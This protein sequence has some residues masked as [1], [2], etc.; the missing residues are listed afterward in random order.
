M[1]TYK[2]KLILC[3]ILFVGWAMNVSAQSTTIKTLEHPR[4][5]MTKSDEAL[6][7][8][9]VKTNKQW[10]MVDSLLMQGA[11]DILIIPVSERIVI[12]RRLLDVSRETLRRILILGYA[13]RISGDTKYSDRAEIEL[14]AVSEFSDW[15][16]SHFLDVAEMTTAVAI[17]Y[18]W[19]YD[20]LTD[21]AKTKI[22]LAILQKGIDPSLDE[23]YNNWLDRVNNWNQVCNTGM[24]YGVIAIYEDIPAIADM[25][26]KRSVESV[27]KPMKSYAPDGAYPEG[28]SY[29]GYGT[30][31][32]V[33]LIDAL[34]KSFGTDFGLSQQQGFLQTAEYML[35]MIAPDR[36]SFNYGDNKDSGRLSPAMFWFANKS[37]DHS[38]LWNER[39]L[40]KE[41]NK[42]KLVNYRFFTLSAIWG[43]N[44]GIDNLPQPQKKV[45]VSDRSL[46]PVALMRTSW[47]RKKGVYLAF[48]GGSALVSHAH[49]DVGSFIM[50]ANG[51]RW[52]MDFGRQDYNSLESKGIDLWNKAQDSDRWKVFR[53]N[54]LAHNTLTF[55]GQF[56]VVEGNAVIESY[57][58]NKDF[59]YAISDITPV[60]AGQVEKSKRGVALVNEKYVVVRDEIK[61]GYKE[62]TVRWTMLT[63]ATAKIKNKNTIELTIKNKKMEI[64][65]E[66]PANIELKTWSTEPTTD[67]DAEN[68]GTILV[69]FETHIPANTE[70]VLQVK[71]VPH[72]AGKAND[73]ISDLGTW[74]THKN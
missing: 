50:V 12:G 16:P 30:T 6:I 23:K 59:S 9:A 36:D 22:K 7:K 66:S 70:R 39:F 56:Q 46:T 69:G 45:L 19:F 44:I 21:D 52:A 2:V 58:D 33:M 63:P 34:E 4:L 35:H 15:N 1:K 67:Y 8:S 40:L 68:P 54:N 14:A 73:K 20:V 71:L 27:K 29:W 41:G 49:L 28:Y 57:S 25:I 38:L 74:T 48:K 43:A 51:E 37:N 61:T 47:E 18:D 5:L 65:V 10:A 42:K 72:N 62:T 31:Y 11:D 17:G 60:Y 24:V 3:T 55:D 26:I 32:N 53:Y 13:Y 64:R